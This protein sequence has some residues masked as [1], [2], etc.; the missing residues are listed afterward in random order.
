MGGLNTILVPEHRPQLFQEPVIF[1]GTT[2]M[3]PLIGND[4]KPS[5]AALATAYSIVVRIQQAREDKDSLVNFYL[6]TGSAQDRDVS[7]RSVGGTF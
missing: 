7:G 4:G 5:I 2:V 1:M 3:H 6:Q